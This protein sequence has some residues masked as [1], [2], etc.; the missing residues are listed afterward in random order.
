MADKK[1]KPK[2]KKGGSK[3]PKAQRL[4]KVRGTASQPVSKKK[5]KKGAK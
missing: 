1:A 3:Q 2:K 5:S 4:S